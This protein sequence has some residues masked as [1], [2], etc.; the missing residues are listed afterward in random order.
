MSEPLPGEQ[1]DE[2]AEIAQR[3]IG[4]FA[5]LFADELAAKPRRS[6]GNMNARDLWRATNDS[7]KRFERGEIA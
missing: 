3:E 5:R 6:D 1:A 2:V 4:R 7:I